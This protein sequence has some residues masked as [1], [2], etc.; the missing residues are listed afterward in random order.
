MGDRVQEVV[1]SRAAKRA[2]GLAQRDGCAAE[3]EELGRAGDG[4]DLEE[5]QESHE[6][7]AQQT[8]AGRV[9]VDDGGQARGH[10]QLG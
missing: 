7:A 10:H 1:V 8:E 2:S 3:K 6:R 9:E 4:A 5:D